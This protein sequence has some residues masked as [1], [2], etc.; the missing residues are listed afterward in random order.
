VSAAAGWSVGWLLGGQP[1]ADGAVQRVGVDTGQYPAHGRL[2]GWPPG[3]GQ[4]VTAHPEWGQHLAGR[5]AGPL[6]DRGQG[7][8]AGQHRG[9]RHG[10]HRDQ[11]V[12]SAPPVAG[13]GDLGEVAEQTTALVGCQRGGRDQPLGNRRNGG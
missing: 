5:V 1:G 9:H 11:R 3:T 8:G 2:P 10:Q 7:S 12:P 6:A 13:V 4:G